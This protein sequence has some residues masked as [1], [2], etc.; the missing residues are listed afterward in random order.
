MTRVE[1]TMSMKNFI[2]TVPGEN[3]LPDNDYL[4][5]MMDAE[6]KK[7]ILIVGNSITRHNPKADI[8]WFGDWG[9][10]ASCAENDYVHIMHR[11]LKEYFGAV[12][13]CIAQA[14]IWE[15]TECAQKQEKLSESYKAAAEFGADLLIIRIGEN[16]DMSRTSVPE[17]VEDFEQMIRFF[18]GKKEGSKVIVTGMFWESPEREEVVRLVAQ[19]KGYHYVPLND[20]GMN[21]KMTAM[22]LFEHTGVAGHPG[23]L[24]MRHIA[25]R[26]MDK[27]KEIYLESE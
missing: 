26:I 15:V 10:A 27:V 18:C 17:L 24:G 11:K 5:Y 2:N 20:L 8:G 4:S 14:A 22:G 13:I 23:D 16:M 25:E 3:Q 6:A 9:M 19:R 21:E 12:S 1:M 7:K